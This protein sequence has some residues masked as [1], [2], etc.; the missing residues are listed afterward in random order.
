MNIVLVTNAMTPYRKFF[1]DK[2][3]AYCKSKGIGF[4]V[5]TMTEQ[6]F[7]YNWNYSEVD[8]PYNTLLKGYHFKRPVVSHA[9][10]GVGK[11]LKALSPDIILLGGSYTNITSWLVLKY[12]K[13][14]NVPVY[15]WS[16]SHLNEARKF[17]SLQ[18]KIRNA[19]KHRFYGQCDGFF[20]AG[21]MSLN[22]IKDANPAAARLHLCPNL[23]DNQKY[24]A[25]GNISKS[26]LRKKWGV[27]ES[28]KVALLPAR[29]H[30]VKGIHLFVD[31][32][33]KAKAGKDVTVLVPGTGIHEKEIRE[34]IARS[35]MDVR[36]LGYQQ[37]KE[38]LELYSVA[39]LFFLPSL[40]DP[41][42]LSCIEAL[43][44]GL[45][46][47]VSDHVGNYPEVIEEG[48]NGYVFSY[49]KPGEA[50]AK[51]DRIITA[52]PEWM[53]KASEKSRKIA[54]DRFNPDK[55]V[56]RLIGDVLRENKPSK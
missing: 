19:V 49:E 46:L 42:P 43:W 2:V 53:H 27:E 22:F 38:M 4:S 20:Y 29:L 37:Q 26:E 14:H 7:G 36:L 24:A 16:E 56:A 45:P 17:G 18:K 8:A 10:P 47:L 9:N 55:V 48:E 15:F 23:I 52:S 51:I 11:A 30:W 54:E 41:N 31:L 44:A 33:A 35:G 13:K 32:L 39:D 25:A 40:S 12:A 21:E 28:K 6:E 50:V 5:L 3:A 34:S 1:Y